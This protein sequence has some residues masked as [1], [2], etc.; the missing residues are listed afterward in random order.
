MFQVRSTV[1]EGWSASF[2]NSRGY[3]AGCAD[4]IMPL[5][6]INP[7]YPNRSLT[8]FRSTKKKSMFYLFDLKSTLN[9]IS[10]FPTKIF[11]SIFV[12]SKRSPTELK[13]YNIDSVNLYLL[14]R[15]VCRWF[16]S[17][18]STSFHNKSRCSYARQTGSLCARNMQ[19]Y[20]WLAVAH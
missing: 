13:N 5:S 17:Q 20:V 6:Q 4:R 1:F 9:W 16:D 7:F 18:T 14:W 8:K 2:T 19:I 12:T 11:Y 3:S 15:S 10:N